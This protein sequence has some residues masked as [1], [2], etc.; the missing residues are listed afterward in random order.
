M[1]PSAA[2][3]TIERLGPDVVA[4]PVAEPEGVDGFRHRPAQRDDAKRVRHGRIRGGL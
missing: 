2:P 4:D 3:A 1:S